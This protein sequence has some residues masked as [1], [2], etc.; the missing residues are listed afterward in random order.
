MSR[1]GILFTLCALF[2]F[3]VP[4]PGVA[5]DDAAK[6]VA[7]G[8]D[9]DSLEK[10]IDES[11]EPP[12]LVPVNKE[13]AEANLAKAT[14]MLS[15]CDKADAGACGPRRSSDLC[16]AIADRNMEIKNYS[17]AQ[18]FYLEAMQRL[19]IVS[20]KAEKDYEAQA[21]LPLDPTS[22]D[23]AKTMTVAYNA[24]KYNHQAFLD[25]VE[26]ARYQKR[27]ARAYVVLGFTDRAK[28]HRDMIDNSI[29]AAAKH[30]REL[31]KNFEAL[32]KIKDKIPEKY[33]SYYREIEALAGAVEVEKK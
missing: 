26:L 1:F 4:N 28:D 22:G 21:K 6:A 25:N 17:D 30:R 3:L 13:K 24:A 27:L 10:R 29:R 33:M 12:A 15:E 32:K 9:F 31:E 19:S 8:A 14:V 7:P 11:T 23:A 16:M 2:F 20:E 5:K 18:A